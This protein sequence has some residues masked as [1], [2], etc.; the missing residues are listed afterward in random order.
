[1]RLR[2]ERIASTMTRVVV[3]RPR[4]QAGPLVERL[5]AT[6]PVWV[7]ASTDGQRIIYRT[8]RPGERETLRADRAIAI[9]VGDA[10]ALRWRIND[11]PDNVMGTRGAVRSV[12]LT[13]EDVRAD[14]SS[15]QPPSVAQTDR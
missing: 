10:A 8:M 5:E 11:G 13:P 1:M 12:R 4:A 9:R 15:L 7:A 14:R 3:T 2:G 6:D